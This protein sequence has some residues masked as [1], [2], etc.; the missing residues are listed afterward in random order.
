VPAEP[1][2][3]ARGTWVAIG[4]ALTAVAVAG[5][6]GVAM[7]PGTSVTPFLFTTLLATAFVA[8]RIALPLSHRGWYTPS[9][10]VV[11]FTGLIGGPIAGAVAGAVTAVGDP[12]GAWRRRLAFGG[13]DA[14]RGF[15]AGLVGLVPAAG[16]TGAVL[17]A[18][19]AVACAFALNAGG[20]RLIH[21]ARAVEQARVF[22]RGLLVDGLEAI[23][24]VPV[25]ALLLQGYR[26]GGAMLV[27]LTAAG[28]L[29]ALWL[30][31]E[32]ARRNRA[33]LQ[34]EQLLARTDP[35]TGAPNRRA[36]EEELRRAHA[37]VVRGERPV[38]LLV[39][40]IDRFKQ[41][42]SRHG[43]DGGDVVLRELVDRLSRALRDTDLLAR[44]GGEEFVVVASSIDSAAALRRL[45]EQLR[46]LVRSI[47]F[48]ADGAVIPVTVSV[49]AALLDG[50]TAPDTV[51]R[52]ANLALAEA[53]HAGDRVV[54]WN[55]RPAGVERRDRF[56]VLIA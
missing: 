2:D 46:L 52:R 9:T 30:A 54:V 14:V 28:L 4:Y 19:L 34:R 47:P 25:L 48:G 31:T 6:W 33:A 36:L 38:G 23:V 42:N 50:A 7:Q 44:R 1:V 3:P 20:L 17:H 29:V 49:G 51:E 13:L 16:P 40:D 32:T 35:L 55:Q 18:A 24:A 8:E 45:A 37:R 15:A 12:E 10:P 27:V 41:I 11:V 43:W 53:K 56:P 5:C 21:Q 22:R 39:L 26:S